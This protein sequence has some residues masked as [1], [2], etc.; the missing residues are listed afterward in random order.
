MRIRGAD[1]IAVDAAGG[2]LGPPA[3]LDGV[4]Q[5]K[6]D[7]T[8]W[9]EFSH[10]HGEQDAAGFAATPNGPVQYAMVD[11]ELALVAQSHRPE[12]AGDGSFSGSTNGS[13]KQ[14]ERTTPNT[15]EKEWGE[16]Y[17]DRY[18]R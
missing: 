14:D 9:S 16:C 4:I 1:G 5:A 15:I 12:R 17:D 8:G 2:N 11:L 10:Q 18:K 3:P 6:H 7:G 13:Y